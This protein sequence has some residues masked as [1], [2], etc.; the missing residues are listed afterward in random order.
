MP[1]DG[2]WNYTTYVDGE[3]TY[4]MIGSSPDD[5]NNYDE[6][7]ATTQGIA[8]SG[9]ITIPNILGGYSVRSLGP[10]SFNNCGIT[11]LLYHHQ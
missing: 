10:K 11:G 7:N 1:T 3:N 8:L 2:I 4:A 6:G 9:A 5:N